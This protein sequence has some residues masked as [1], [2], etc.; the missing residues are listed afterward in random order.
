M[1]A[2][3]VIEPGKVELIDL[4]FAR[5]RPLPGAGQDRG[6]LP[7]QRHR[8]QAGRRPFPGRGQVSAGPGPRVGRHRRGR[9]P[10][11]PQLQASAIGSSAGC[12]SSSA[13]PRYS[14]G[15]GGFCDYTLAND[16]DA[17]VA[18]GVADAA[19]RLVRVLRDPAAGAAG[20]SG[21]RG[22]AALHLAR[23]LRRLR[24]FPPP[25]GRRHPD[26]RRRAGG[27]ELRQ[28]RQAAGAGLDRRRRSAAGTNARR[29]WPWGPTPSSHPI[30]ESLRKLSKT[31][32]KPLDAVI[33]AV[34]SP[35]IVNAALPLVKMGGTICVYGVIAD[36]SI[37]ID[38]S[39]ARTTSTCSCTSGR[40]GRASGPPRSRS[41]SGSA[42]ASSPR[43][44]FV[45]HDFP[46]ERIND[47]LAAV[48]SG[49]VIKAIL[50]Y[51]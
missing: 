11:G 10:E 26:L 44:E 4:P 8:R 9:G 39:R 32:G 5:A 46:V 33:D 38:K 47:A 2:V 13:I 51:G 37:T 23:G 19:A 18:D 27:A 42:K 35:A 24:R 28:V 29:P 15:W 25:A 12:C 40:R 50:R 21:R 17:M 30:A 6:G 43:G 31:R 16:H 7:V 36:E 41:A 45:T 49:E 48:G 3:V 22:R 1:R 34:G 14:S 20:H